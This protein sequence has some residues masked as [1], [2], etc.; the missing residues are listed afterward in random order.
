ME[1]LLDC[2]ITWE[3]LGYK[4]LVS[5]LRK[6]WG[7]Q[8]DFEATDLGLGFFLVKFEMQVNCSKVYMEGS[9]IIMDHCLTV[10]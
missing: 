2:Q 4:L 10:R 6:I 3:T 1:G 8:G 7:L 9:W 5:K